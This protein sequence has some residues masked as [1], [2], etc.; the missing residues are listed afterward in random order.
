MDIEIASFPAASLIY[1]SVGSIIKLDGRKQE[2]KQVK[3]NWHYVLE[4][5]SPQ[6]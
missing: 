1:G 2:Q 4:E 3:E 5:R 6:I